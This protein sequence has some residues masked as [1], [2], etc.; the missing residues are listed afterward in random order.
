[1]RFLS[2]SVLLLQVMIRG[3]RPKR[4]NIVHLKLAQKSYRFMC[5]VSVPVAINDSLE[6]PSVPLPLCPSAQIVGKTIVDT[7]GQPNRTTNL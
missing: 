6:R 7:V 2:S 4:A 1:M 3:F 5:R